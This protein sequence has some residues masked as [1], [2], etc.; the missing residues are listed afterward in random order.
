[1]RSL[2][3]CCNFLSRPRRVMNVDISYHIA[4]QMETNP[5]DEYQINKKK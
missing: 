3:L 4:T 2:S 5:N 1:M